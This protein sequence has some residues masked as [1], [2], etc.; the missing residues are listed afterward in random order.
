MNYIL[1]NV[2]IYSFIIFLAWGI[3]YQWNPV[4]ALAK[5]GDVI[6]WSW[7]TPSWIYSFTHRIEQ[8]K[9]ETATE[10]AV[11]GF[12]SGQVGTANGKFKTEK[13]FLLLITTY[14]FL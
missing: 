3:G 8:T 10:P 12:V 5:V 14:V 2:E 1:N 4:V 7:T 13:L 11:D 9:N 6:E